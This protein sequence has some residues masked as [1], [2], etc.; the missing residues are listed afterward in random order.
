MEL[1]VLPEFHCSICG[2]V[3]NTEMGLVNHVVLK[4]DIPAKTYY[5]RTKRKDGE[6]ICP[7]CGK[8]TEY[9]DI[10][11]GYQRF[12]STK[13]AVA[14][15]RQHA[16]ATDIK[17]EECGQVFSAESKNKAAQIFQKHI[18]EAHNLQPKDYYDK[19]IR[20]PDE[21]ICENCGKETNFVKMSLGYNKYCCRECSV[22]AMIKR[23]EAERQKA[24]EYDEAK[25]QVII[26]EEMRQAEWQKEC[27][28]RLAEFENPDRCT[29]NRTDF[30]I[31]G[32]FGVMTEWL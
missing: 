21:G 9:Q 30:G 8:E 10:S 2:V 16:E 13:C 28:R 23:R 6:G 20:K 12:C 26:T 11:R 29:F 7:I 5:D 27:Q 32:R 22:A 1:K 4:H 18:R 24:K 19:Y 17:C 31:Q 3:L 15:Q 25:A 14:W